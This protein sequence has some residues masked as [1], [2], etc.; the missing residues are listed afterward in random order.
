MPTRQGVQNPQLSW[1]KKCVKLRATSNMS[2]LATEH[3]ERAGRRN[4]LERDAAVEF[5]PW[6]AGAGRPAHL[7]GVAPCA[8]PQSASTW[9]TVTPNGYS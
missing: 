6:N 9:R 5:A 4:V 1:A 3:H 2:R 8:P 7:H